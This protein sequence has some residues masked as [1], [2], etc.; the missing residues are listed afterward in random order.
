MPSVKKLLEFFEISL[1]SQRLS[2]KDFKEFSEKGKYVLTFY[3]KKQK[4]NFDK[5]DLVELNFKN[6]NVVINGAKLSGKV[7]KIKKI[8]KNLLQVFDFKTGDALVK[9]DTSL[10][11]QKYKDQLVFYKL[12]IENSRDYSKYKVNEGV[13]EFVE[14]VDEEIIL[15]SHFITDV[16]VE[17]M[18]K[19]ISIVYNKIM[20]LDFPDVNIYPKDS[21]GEFTNSSF[22]EFR[23]DLLEGNI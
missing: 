18:K 7:D 14:D 11:S 21:N 10:K 15:L 9:W 17:E 19:L 5:N 8:D 1:N 6:Q 4:N 23:K 16:E 13:M 2:K 12:L 22:K 20:N 3:Y